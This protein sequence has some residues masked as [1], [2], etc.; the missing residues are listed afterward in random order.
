MSGLSEEYPEAI[1]FMCGMILMYKRRKKSKVGLIRRLLQGE[2]L[3]S[4][5]A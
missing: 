2:K 4:E 3:K 5:Y 1:S